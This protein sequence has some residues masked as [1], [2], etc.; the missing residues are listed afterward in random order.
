ML[1]S[2]NRS[3]L[4]AGQLSTAPLFPETCSSVCEIYQSIVIWNPEISSAE[5]SAGISPEIEFKQYLAEDLRS[6][7][8][9]DLSAV[10]QV[11]P[12]LCKFLPDVCVGNI[13]LIRILVSSLLPNKV[14][15]SD[16]EISIYMLLIIN[17][18]SCGCD[19][20]LVL[21]VSSAAII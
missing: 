15:A 10:Q 21:L 14:K 19:R 4:E 16:I 6:L 13:E 12:I 2:M 5:A 17:L 11:T 8:D 7:Q 20:Y 9:S 3:V 1:T 18:I